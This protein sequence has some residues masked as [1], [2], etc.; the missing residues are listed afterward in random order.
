MPGPERLVNLKRP[1]D[2]GETKIALSPLFVGAE[3]NA[4]LFE[5]ISAD[6]RGQPS[7]SRFCFGAARYGPLG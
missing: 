1:V 2:M 4:F 7:H 5:P 3:F 6:N